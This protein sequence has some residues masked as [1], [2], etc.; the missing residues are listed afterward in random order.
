MKI[1]TQVKL[2]KSKFELEPPAGVFS[3]G[4]CFSVCIPKHL[5]SSKYSVFSNPCGITYNPMSVANQLNALNNQ[6]PLSSTVFIEG[7]PYPLEHHGSFKK[8][9]LDEQ[10]QNILDVWSVA[11][12]QF[13]DA[14]MLLITLGT[15]FAFTYKDRFVNNCHRLPSKV[16]QEQLLSVEQIVS[17]LK[18]PL[19]NWLNKD[20]N[21]RVVLSVSPVRHLRNGLSGNSV[22]KSTLRVACFQLSQMSGVLYFPSYEIMLDELRGY[23]F[24]KDDL[25]HPSNLSEQIIWRRF[26]SWIL[27]QR[28]EELC[29]LV[30]KLERSLAHSF[31]GTP[32][33]S[34]IK[35]LERIMSQL[36]QKYPDL[37]WSEEKARCKERTSKSI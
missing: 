37:D 27:S 23:R 11:Q 20:E 4:S 36:E 2:S 25:L 14:Q 17:A 15:A 29:D 28:S 34:W 26:Q 9:T 33:P 10:K 13:N 24:Y 3:I 19:C 8:T 30:S 35:A 1:H 31:E 22:S 18:K 6:T 12:E 21:K 32:E 7:K 16:F 5:K